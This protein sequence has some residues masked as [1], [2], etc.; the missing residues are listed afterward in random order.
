ML[1]IRSRI[2]VKLRDVP[3]YIV[4]GMLGEGELPKNVTAVDLR[5][6][7]GE[8]DELVVYAEVEAS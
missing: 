7:E 8:Q 1:I 3:H 2:V 4:K 6:D 5:L